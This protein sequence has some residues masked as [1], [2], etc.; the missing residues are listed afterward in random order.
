M[1]KNQRWSRQKSAAFDLMRPDAIY[2]LATERPVSATEWNFDGTPLKRFGHNRPCWPVRIGITTSRKDTISAN[3]KGPLAQVSQQG[4]IW[5]PGTTQGISHAPL[6]A[7]LANEWLVRQEEDAGAPALYS[8]FHDLMVAL[9][10]EE[11]VIR[12]EGEHHP[13]RRLE[14]EILQL[15]KRKAM[16]AWSDEELSQFLDRALRLTSS[17]GIQIISDRGRRVYAHDSAFLN[18]VDRMVEQEVAK[19]SP[20]LGRAG[21]CR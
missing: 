10:L 11:F 16:L 14:S 2:I 19:Q 1:T 5:L 4:T 20:P 3:Y 12:A 17:K 21:A 6:L 18:V 7:R 15:A 8:D 9:N 13:I